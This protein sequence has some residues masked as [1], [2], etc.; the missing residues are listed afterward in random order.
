MKKKNTASIDVPSNKY[1]CYYFIVP[2]KFLGSTKCTHTPSCK[3]M[4]VHQEV[5]T[6]GPHEGHLALNGC[7]LEKNYLR[8]PFHYTCLQQSHV[9]METLMARV[10][11]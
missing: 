3:V 1:V 11:S 6:Q 4:D 2:F 10:T 5:P 8:R 9:S 7:F